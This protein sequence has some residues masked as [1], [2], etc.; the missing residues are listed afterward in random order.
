MPRNTNKRKSSSRSGLISAWLMLSVVVI[1][2]DQLTKILVVRRFSFAERLNMIP[3]FFDLTLLYNKGAAFSFLANAG[4]WQRWFFIGIGV[5]ASVLI[6][7]MLAKHTG[8]TLFCLALALILGGAIGNVIDR[9]RLGK[10]VDFLLFYIHPH[11]FPAFNV[12]DAAI[13]CGAILLIVD[14]IRRVRKAG[15]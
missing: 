11:Y 14:E 4:G 10:V 12:A 13:T 15:R 2:L 6:I 8:Q 5:I 9:V 7:W 3:N 1:L